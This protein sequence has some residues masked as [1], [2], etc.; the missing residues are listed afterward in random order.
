MRLSYR[1]SYRT[2]LL[3]GVSTYILKNAYVCPKEILILLFE[4]S[5]NAAKKNQW[6]QIIG[7]SVLLRWINHSHDDI[8]QW[9]KRVLKE[10]DNY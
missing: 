10:L 8:S 3:H 1:G 7:L 5:L 4:V 6:E 9:G 2:T